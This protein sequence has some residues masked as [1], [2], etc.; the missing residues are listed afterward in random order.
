MQQVL[1]LTRL[2]GLLST[3]RHAV[4]C[5]APASHIDNL[6]QVGVYGGFQ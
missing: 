1:S 4:Q 3:S 6:P 5:I 2:T